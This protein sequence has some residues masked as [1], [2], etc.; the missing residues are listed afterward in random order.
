M[1]EVIAWAS[2][3]ALILVPLMSIIW[4]C[5]SWSRFKETIPFTP[6]H[7][8]KKVMFII[9]AVITAIVMSIYLVIMG[10]YGVK[11]FFADLIG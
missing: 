2:L 1:N 4:M 7:P 11:V 6:E 10:I 8:K 9:S 5:L 3:I